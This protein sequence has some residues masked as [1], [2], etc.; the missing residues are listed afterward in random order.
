[1]TRRIPWRTIRLYGLT[2]L[3]GFVSAYLIVALVLLP[4][5]RSRGRVTT[6]ALVGLSLDEARHV[7][8]SVGLRFTLGDERASADVPRNRVLAQSPLPG[9]NAPRLAS[10]TLDISAGPRQLRVPS[11]AGLTLE[12]ARKVLADSGLTAG[13]P[14]EESSSAPR[15]EVLRTN[16]DAGRI[17]GEG[18]SVQLVISTGPPDLTMPDVLGREQ[19]DALAVLNQLGLTRVRVDSEPS[20]TGGTTGVVV[21][22]T[23]AAGTGV[24][25]T[26]RIVLRVSPRP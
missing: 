25:T 12:D 16:P 22:Q 4:G 24:R 2:A 19:T 7:L 9:T 11:V 20:T 13:N 14:K 21:S 23:P 5:A 18:A 8:D 15:G 10:V 1:V 6:P 26:D 17:V 3:A